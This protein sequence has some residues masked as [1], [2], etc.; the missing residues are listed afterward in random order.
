MMVQRR[1]E[2][3]L[4]TAR[5]SEP[6]I[7]HA[8]QRTHVSWQTR[9]PPHHPRLPKLQRLGQRRRLLL[10]LLGLVR[11]L[12]AAASRDRATPQARK[13]RPRRS[14]PRALLQPVSITRSISSMWSTLRVTRLASDSKQPSWSNTRSAGSRL[15]LKPTRS[16]SFR[17]Q[18][19]MCGLMSQF[20]FW[21]M[22]THSV[23][24]ASWPSSAAISGTSLQAISKVA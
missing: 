10:N 20:S 16:V 3:K 14:L 22:N 23:S 5:R 11:L 19:L 12:L 15:P 13:R 7:L 6:Q 21:A 4:R 24:V 2:R 1:K 9:S 17:K 18:R 8:R